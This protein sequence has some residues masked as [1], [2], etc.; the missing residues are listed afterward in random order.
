MIKQNFGHVYSSRQFKF[1]LP[2]GHDCSPRKK[3]LSWPLREQPK[4]CPP[5]NNHVPLK[6]NLNHVSSKMR[7]KLCDI[8]IFI[9]EF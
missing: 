4:S 3:G 6:N 2:E 8:I 9:F 7:S 5:G 1:L